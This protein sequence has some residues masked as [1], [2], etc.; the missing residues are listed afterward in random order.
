MDVTRNPYVNGTAYALAAT[1]TI[2]AQLHEV[3]W[4]EYVCKPMLM[5]ILGSWFYFN[6]RR[7]GDR[8]TLLVQGGLFFSLIGDVTLMMVHVDGYNFLVGLAAFMLAHVCYTIAFAHNI[9]QADGTDGLALGGLIAVLMLSVGFF[10]INDLLRYLDADLSVPVIVYSACIVLMGIAAGF[11]YQRTYP[12]SFWMVF[13]GSLLFMF[14]DTLLGMN[15]FVRPVPMGSLW[16]MGTYVLAQFLIAAGCLLHVLDPDSI[17][18]KA[19]L[20]A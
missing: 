1:G 5:V 13:I 11:R 9:F 4:L 14:S 16:I 18:R 2:V 17:R 3:H 12:R 8:F 6:S 20:E 19:A 10:V 15:R 7:Y